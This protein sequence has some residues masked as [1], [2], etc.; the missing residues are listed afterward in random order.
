MIK[1]YRLSDFYGDFSAIQ[2]DW[3]MRKGVCFMHKRTRGR[4]REKQRDLTSTPDY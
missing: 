2:R 4:H 1:D 3:F